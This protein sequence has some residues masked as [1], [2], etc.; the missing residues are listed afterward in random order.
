MLLRQWLPVLQ[1]YFLT[2]SAD[3]PYSLADGLYE[4][5][6]CWRWPG[7]V[8]PPHPILVW[9]LFLAYAASLA[10]TEV[11]ERALIGDFAKKEERA[12]AFG[13]YHMVVGLAVL[14][15]AII[16]GIVW[17]L[18]GPATAFFMNGLFST[19]AVLLLTVQYRKY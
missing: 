17:Q 2:E 13:L 18:L 4:Y 3:F 11:A 9:P 16:F 15:G 6:S 5:V 19:G 14:P 10:M 12:T 1:V 7:V 8:L